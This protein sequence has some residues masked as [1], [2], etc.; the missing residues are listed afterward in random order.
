MAGTSIPMILLVG[1]LFF[2][3]WEL[4]DTSISAIE[5]GREIF[6]FAVILCLTFIVIALRLNF[7]VGKSILNPIG[8]MLGIVGKVRD[9]DFTQ[10]IRVLSNDEIGILGDAGNNMIAGL[11]ER[12]KIRAT[13][14]KY[15]TPEIRDHILAG[16]IP[17]NGQ[18][19]QATLLFSDLRD[20]TSY[21]EKNDPEEVIRSMRAYF[22]AMQKAI[23]KHQGLVLQYVGDEVE[24]VFGVP[25]Q[26]EGHV[27]KA[28]LAAIGMRKSLEELNRF[29]A[30][31]GKE[32]FR[33][34]IGIHT[35]EVLAG[36]T[37]S[38]DRLSYTL[39]G[40]TVNLASRI[41]EL[42]KEFRCDIL[43][44][45]EAVKSLENGFDMKKESPSMIKGYSTPITVFQVLT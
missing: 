35:G 44:S 12:E 13:F 14:G 33:H 25:R 41:Q 45:E 19:T 38:E 3:L 7:L 22:T 2:V 28:V 34:G 17:L 9:G 11:L 8:E 4:E 6:I 5:L 30:E 43:V 31:E 29:R 40:D 26:H 1:T 39:I 15:V 24:A 21:V 10:R 23:R 37:G 20:F 36:N 42:T 32:P 27:D 18:R 16:R